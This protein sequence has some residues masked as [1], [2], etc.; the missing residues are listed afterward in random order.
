M[1]VKVY[2]SHAIFQ[3]KNTNLIRVPSLYK[4]KFAFTE[5]FN[6][7]KYPKCRSFNTK[8]VRNNYAINESFIPNEF[9]L[10]KITFQYQT[11]NL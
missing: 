3:P 11:L 6:T 4:C 2:H 9:L 7:A 1:R 5:N 10:T 8:Y